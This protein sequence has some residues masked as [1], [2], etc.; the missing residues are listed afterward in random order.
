MSTPIR[1]RSYQKK[2]VYKS[3]TPDTPPNTWEGL[4]LSNQGLRNLTP[5]IF[6]HVFLKELRIEGNLLKEVPVEI[7]ELEY[8]EVLNASNNKLMK[9]PVDLCKCKNL[10]YLDLSDNLLSSIPLELGNLYQIEHLDL[11]RNPLIEPFSSIYR[12]RGG[13]GLLA[14]CRDNN[15]VY[16]EP[17][18]RQWLLI[19]LN[20]EE[21]ELIKVASYN[22]LAARC[23]N[24]KNYPF[25]PTNTLKPEWRFESIVNEIVSYNVDILCLQEVEN[26][27]YK[28]FF[29]VTLEEK[30]FYDSFFFPKSRIKAVSG[31]EKDNVDGCVIFWKRNLFK[32]IDQKNIEFVKLIAEHPDF[33]KHEDILIRNIDK[34]NVA[35][36]ILLQKINNDQIIVV[37]AHLHWNHDYSDIKLFQSVIL[38]E[39]IMKFRKK[40]PKAGVL[41][42][43]DFNSLKE[44]DVINFIKDGQVRFSYK[45]KSFD[46]KH[47][48]KILDTHESVDIPFTHFHMNFKG[49]IDYIFCTDNIGIEKVLLPPNEDYFDSVLALPTVH[50]PSD[51]LMIGAEVYLK[52][53]NE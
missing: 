29:S 19:N 22:I 13:I 46:F 3:N 38:L 49:T 11:D 43:G 34:D 21:R 33:S 17:F 35:S 5:E 20:Y 1:K 9:V 28:S 50:F 53:N 41:I 23:C 51:H 16:P 8:L 52:K 44:S 31:S 6:E 7:S 45:E 47:S 10:K 12:Q 37:N 36:V 4:D 27:I 48:L 24:S 42:C 32:L 40:Y 15:L 2:S 30:C 39:E 26:M 25:L 18:D 14:F